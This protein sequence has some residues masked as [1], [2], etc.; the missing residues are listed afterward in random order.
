MKK[1]RFI[2]LVNL[3][4]RVAKVIV[5]AKNVMKAILKVFNKFQHK[6]D[7]FNHYSVNY[8]CRGASEVNTPT[9]VC[10]SLSF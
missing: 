7:N 3:G 2:V 5:H 8:T 10:S 6:Q 4:H 9:N 1:S